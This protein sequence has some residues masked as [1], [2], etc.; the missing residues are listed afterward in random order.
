M[1]E[2]LGE[3]DVN[4]PELKEQLDSLGTSPDQVSRLRLE[5]ALQGT[6]VLGLPS[7]SLVPSS[8]QT[9]RCEMIMSDGSCGMAIVDCL[10]SDTLDRVSCF[11]LVRDLNIPG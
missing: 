11:S 8:Q 1:Q 9:S 7:S 3:F 2:M 4:S 10:L 6:A 5:S